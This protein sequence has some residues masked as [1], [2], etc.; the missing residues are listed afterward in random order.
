MKP[1]DCSGDGDPEEQGQPVAAVVSGAPRSPAILHVFDT[2]TSRILT[3]G[4]RAESF[5]RVS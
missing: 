1:I 2:S 3:A 5:V 4:L